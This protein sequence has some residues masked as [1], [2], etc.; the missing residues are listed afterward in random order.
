MVVWAAPAAPVEV[1]A[2]AVPGAV[3]ALLGT[4]VFATSF[5]TAEVDGRAASGAVVAG[6][7]P[8]TSRGA[9]WS[10]AG[11]STLWAAASMISAAMAPSKTTRGS[12]AK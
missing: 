8:G 4:P 6:T 9:L 5:A 1:T 11:G 12:R 7:A 10:A 3:D 2:W